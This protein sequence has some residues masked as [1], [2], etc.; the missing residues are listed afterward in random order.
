MAHDRAVRFLVALGEASTS[1]VLNLGQIARTN[2]RNR[3]YAERPLFVSPVLNTAF[4]V[5]QRMRESEAF[6]FDSSRAVITIIIAPFDPTDL[7]AGGRSVIVDQ[8]GFKESIRALGS[9]NDK[10]LARDLEVLRLRNAPPSL[11]P[12]LLRQH[13]TNYRVD[14]APCYFP[15]S[16][17]DQQSM[18]AYVSI[19]L[20]RLTKLLGSD[21]SASATRRIVTAMLSSDVAE[22][23]A[24]P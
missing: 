18:H 24:P 10:D 6:L 4:V 23:L 13:L 9:Y 16:Q 21:A 3:E 7:S 22:E 14:V 1:R 11:D 12:F 17:C 5:K 20:T 2:S 15:I 8:R 19:E